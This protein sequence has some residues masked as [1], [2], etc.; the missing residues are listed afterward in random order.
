MKRNVIAKAVETIE[1]KE[2]I[3][4]ENLGLLDSNSTRKF[5]DL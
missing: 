2:L 5:I 1:Q 3:L 4:R